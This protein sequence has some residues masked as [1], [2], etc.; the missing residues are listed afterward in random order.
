MKNTKLNRLASILII[1][2]FL[3]SCGGGSDGGT[4]N[5]PPIDTRSS[6]WDGM[7]WDQDNWG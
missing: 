7:V 6:H 3:S 1:V 2:G 5:S 4:A